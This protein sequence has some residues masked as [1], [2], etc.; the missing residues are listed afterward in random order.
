MAKDCSFG[1]QFDARVRDQLFMAVDTEIYFPNLA[2]ENFK[3]QTLTSQETF[4]RILNMERAFGS[5]NRPTCVNAV[6]SVNQGLQKKGKQNFSSSQPRSRPSE[7]KPSRGNKSKVSCTHCGYP[8]D[9][10][11]CSF[12]DLACNIC[13]K[14]GHLKA[15]C[16]Y[17]DSSQSL[18]SKNK[19]EKRKK[20]GFS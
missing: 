9:S 20:D 3:L 10:E 5:E 12:K 2:A 17:K 8:H 4:E 13:G 19:K 7:G 11:N 1:N 15:V 14:K 18:N 6:V 16:W